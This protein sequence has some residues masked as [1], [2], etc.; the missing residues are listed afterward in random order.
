MKREEN[1][2]LEIDRDLKFPHIFVLN[3]SAGSGK[4]H[5]LSL[6]FIQFLLSPGIKNN[7][8]QNTL[9]NMLAITFTNKASNEM[10][11]RILR[12]VK[13]IAIGDKDAL[14]SAQQVISLSSEMLQTASYRLIDEMIRRYTDF[15]VRTIDSFLRSIIMASLRETNLQPGFDIAM[16]PVPY[17]EYAVDDL[18]SKIRTVPAV[19]KLFLTFLDIYLS[20]EGKTSFYPRRDI[21]KIVD[22]FRYQENKRGKH[23]E[24]TRITLDKLREK[25]ERLKK[26]INDLYD[27]ISANRIE[28]NKRNLPERD[29]LIDRID[30]DKL[31]NQIWKEPGIGYVLKN[32]SMH[33]KDTLQHMWDTV[34]EQLA[35]FLIASDNSRYSVYHDILTAIGDI[36]GTLTMTRG[37]ILIDDINSYVRD[38]IDTYR[39]PELYFNL[40]ENIFHYFID[41]F[42]DTDRA[43]WNNI[44]SLVLEALAG[45]GSLFYVGD[46]KQSI[47][48]FKGS[49]ASLFDE[50][51]EDEEIKPV[52]R[53]IY[54]KQLNSN[55]R[56][57]P[58]LVDF[59]NETFC[60]ASLKKMLAD[61]D[62]PI[63]SKINTRLELLIDSVYGN[64]SQTPVQD[65]ARQKTDGYLSIEYLKPGE[66]P[67][68]AVLQPPDN[69]ENGEQSGDE[70]AVIART[71]SVIADLHNRGTS[72]SNIA[73]LVR[74]NGE[75]KTLSGALKLRGIPVQSAQGFD[76]RDHAL[77]RE[78]ISF[79][80]FLNNPLDDL[81][82]AGFISGEIFKTRSG[83]STGT[84]HDW[85][86]RQ[87]GTGHLYS[88]FKLWQPALWN[89]LIRPLLNSVGYLPVYD[90]VHEFMARF[91]VDEHFGS[92]AGFFMHLLEMLKKREDEGDNNLDSFLEYWTSRPE[93]GTDFFVNLSSGNAV[94]IL[95]IHKS[96][97]LEFPV[98]I[99][100]AL[101]FSSA[102]AGKSDMIIIESPDKLSLSYTDKDHR[103]I[104]DS[105]QNSDP[106][107]NAYI[108]EEALSFMDELN[109]FYVAAT[110]AKQE[111]YIFLQ[112]EKDP[113][114]KLFKSRLASGNRYEQGVHAVSEKHQTNEDVFPGKV[115]ASTHWQNHIF[116]KQPD[117]DS[118]EHY[119]E[120]RRGDI[121]HGLLAQITGTGSNPEEQINGLF[122]LIKEDGV[123][124]LVGNP[125]TLK[126]TLSLQAIQS[127]LN[128]G[129]PA[130]VFT[131][132]EVV[133]QK[134]ETKRIDRLVVTTEEAIIIDYKTGGLKDLD[135]H[136]K[137]VHEYMELISEIYP[138]KRTKGFLLYLD[139]K[140]FEEVG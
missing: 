29:L 25:K 34:R 21:V 17:I 122:S 86:L 116:I 130:E 129:P 90:I 100:P 75:V 16:D 113:V 40:G 68:D 35:D 22:R 107:V 138:E 31:S 85:F 80:G 5:N 32:Q 115:Q 54:R 71:G 48:R 51:A 8:A 19:K 70:A 106:S 14:S 97:G 132:K 117:R 12:Q 30:S 94:R 2:V 88:G 87:R 120:E 119:G 53:E 89:D 4:T 67:E 134:G 109:A 63:G 125:E 127:W 65:P 44:R 66:D 123:R 84:L 37:E 23:I 79:L 18:L 73:L 136:K 10:K 42:Q 114:Y 60:P 62:D 55:H 74:T 36:L 72:Y 99:L 39:V 103:S 76:I 6:R 43:Q 69:L 140:R 133:T 112:D 24:C 96:K 92:S 81:L 15:H 9:N 126:E 83:L 82:F 78:T 111:L 7:L 101:S 135:K 124:Q 20:V 41:E 50:A 59:F 61:K 38:L 46:K 45:G 121:I 139:H 118:L 98:V 91:N 28:V 26:S 57:A 131:E 52:L 137:Q 58:L 1:S 108:K 77:I 102:K 27:G 95:T 56:S 128:P 47:Y 104:L 49:D 11:E 105:M 64:S 13:R 3:A 93:D 33:L 110:R